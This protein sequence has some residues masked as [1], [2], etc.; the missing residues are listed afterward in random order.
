MSVTPPGPPATTPRRQWPVLAALT[1]GVVVGHWALLLGAPLALA[2]SAEPDT[3]ASR[4]FTTR[5]IAAPPPSSPRAIPASPPPTTA[6]PVQRAAKAGVPGNVTADNVAAVE[7]VPPEALAEIAQNVTEPIAE[8]PSVD[9]PVQVAAA[10]P[11]PQPAE[12]AAPLAAP[13]IR[14]YAI[15][16]S[17][18]LQY[19]VNGVVG[20]PYTGGGELLWSQDGK[21]YDSRLVISK[22][23]FKL[24][25]WTS[26]GTLTPQGLEPTR[27]GDKTRSEVAAHFERAK[28]KVSFSANTPDAPLLPGAQDHLSV[29]MQLASMLAGDAGRFA[30][31]TKVAFQAVGARASESWV[32]V[33]GTTEKQQLPGGDVEAIKLTREPS[34][35]YSTKVEVWLAPTMEYI[36]V[37]I[38][39][40][41]GNGDF[42]DLLWS[43]TQK[44]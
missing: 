28:N 9:A 13:D 11:T 16:G 18:R 21:T 32:F 31:G 1:L 23:G 39:L 25:T 42:A 15:P 2:T 40:S 24:R 4:A 22:F 20:F 43:S 17:V 19:D 44:P 29:F 12:A 7:T 26:T 37:H 3:M 36:P 5:N 30:P 10:K 6:P 38:R 34:G 35:Q 8:T 33:V 14:T 27:F 41:E